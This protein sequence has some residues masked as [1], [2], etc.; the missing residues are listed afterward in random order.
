MGLPARG[1]V[2]PRL[3]KK[4]AFL[5]RVHEPRAG[6]GIPEAELSELLELLQLFELIRVN[7]SYS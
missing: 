4:L 7:P 1:A 6:L 2:E 3:W 5:G